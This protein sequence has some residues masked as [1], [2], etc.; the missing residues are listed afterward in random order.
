MYSSEAEYL[1]DL[2]EASTANETLKVKAFATEVVGDQIL[3]RMEPVDDP[4]FSL[5]TTPENIIEMKKSQKIFI[6]NATNN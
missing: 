4:S 3:E 5:A 1:A 2:Q 6:F